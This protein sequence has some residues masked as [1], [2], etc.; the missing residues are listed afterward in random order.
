MNGT[1]S[2]DVMNNYYNRT[3]GPIMSAIVDEMKR[4]FLTKTALT[5]NQSIQFFIDPFKLLTISSLA[6]VSDSL[7]KN[8]IMTSNEFRGVIALPPSD[9]PQADQLR[10]PNI[11]PVDSGV[12]GEDLGADEFNAM[13]DDLEG[14]IDSILN[15]G[16]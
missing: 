6:S 4:K 16:D 3:I 11:N 13:L 12:E 9:D 14:Q 2:P 5:Q 7:T 10:N 15:G 8:Q 1:A